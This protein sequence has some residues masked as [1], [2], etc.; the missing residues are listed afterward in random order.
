MSQQCVLATNSI[1]GCINRVVALGQGGDRPPLFCPYEAPFRVLRP[2]L[3][4][5]VQEG[6]GVVGAG[7]EEGHEDAQRAGASLL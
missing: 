5:P 4:P 6:R 3:G 7:P 2:G 1:L